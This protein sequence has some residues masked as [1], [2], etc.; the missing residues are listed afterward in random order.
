VE[1][2]H[3]RR[4]KETRNS[5]VNPVDPNFIRHADSRVVCSTH[6]R[7]DQ[8]AS[9][10]RAEMTRF[11]NAMLRGFTSALNVYVSARD[12]FHAHPRAQSVEARSRSWF[13]KVLKRDIGGEESSFMWHIKKYAKNH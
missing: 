11:L 13:F 12:N 10:N 8:I 3:T 4:M 7:N 2:I 9:I 1:T 5:R 6:A